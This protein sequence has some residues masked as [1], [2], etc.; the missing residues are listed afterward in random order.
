M[1][2]RDVSDET[3]DATLQDALASAKTERERLSLALLIEGLRPVL[4]PRRIARGMPKTW[5]LVGWAGRAIGG[6]IPIYSPSGR[7]IEGHDQNRRTLILFLAT[8]SSADGTARPATT[9]EIARRYGG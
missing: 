1:S 9:E 6:K 7:R 3:L 5:I 8:L 4:V 2:T